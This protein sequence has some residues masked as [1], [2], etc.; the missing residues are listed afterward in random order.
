MNICHIIFTNNFAGSEKYC[1]DLANHQAKENNQVLI[2]T[3]K[4]KKSKININD[5]LFED[6]ISEEINFLFKKYQ[7]KKLLK[8]YNIQIIHAHLGKACKLIEKID[9]PKIVTLHIDYREKQHKNFNGIIC[10]NENQLEKAKNFKGSKKLIYNWTPEIQIKKTSKFEIIKKNIIGTDDNYIF[11]YF[12]RFNKSKNIE[13]LID[14]FKVANISNSKLLLVGDGEQKKFLKNR[15]KNN[16]D[17][18]FLESQKN[19]YPF[20]ELIDCFVLPSRFEP[21]GLVV[22]EAMHFKKK[23]ICTNV[24]ISKFLPKS[25]V[26]SFDDPI[27]LANLLKKASQKG[28]EHINYDLSEFNR[29][30]QILKIN[31][32]YSEIIN[33]Y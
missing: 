4:R 5:F 10:I 16:K 28:K 21:F 15:A 25:S 7:I 29:D 31:N 6:I 13:L 22:L 19:I 11:G 33:N 9:I 14:S 30:N 2:I 12:G 3:S 1:S 8:K 27:E 26:L 23:I 17:I 18:I 24:P 20:Y 32:F